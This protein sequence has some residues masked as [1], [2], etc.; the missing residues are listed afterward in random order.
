MKD[1]RGP[2]IAPRLEHPATLPV[3]RIGQEKTGRIAQLRVFVHDDEALSSIP[4]KPYHLGKRPILLRVAI[5]AADTHWSKT[6]RMVALQLC[7]HGIHAPPL[8]LPL[9]MPGAFHLT[10]P[11][12][13]H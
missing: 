7:G 6:F 11:V 4:F 9:D 3:V 13:A 1:F 2:A 10:D 12:F 8:A 5:A